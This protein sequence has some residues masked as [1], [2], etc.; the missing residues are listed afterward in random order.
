MASAD[1]DD[2]TADPFL[3]QAAY[4]SADGS[5]LLKSSLYIPPSNYSAYAPLASTLPRPPAVETARRELPVVRAEGEV[6]E[7]LASSDVV[8]LCGE[9]GSGKTTQ[10]PQMLLE[11]G[12]ATPADK[13]QRIPQAEVGKD[14]ARPNA[15]FRGFPGLIAVTQPR[16]VAATSMAH[17]VAA[18]LGATVGPTGPVGYQIRYSSGTVGPGTRLKFCTDGILLREA[19]SDLLLSK[20]SAIILDEAHERNVNTD[21]LI[22][23]L[24][25]AVTLRNMIAREQAEET[26]AAAASPSSD[27]A[28][29]SCSDAGAPLPLGPLKLIIMSATLRVGD[30]TGNPHL[31]PRPV[32]P[33]PSL[34]IGS[35]GSG[36]PPVLNVQ[37]RQ[38]PVTAHFA[39]KTELLD[40][41]GEAVAKA[42]KVHARLPEGGILI[43]LTGA[44]E[45]EDVVKRLRQRFDPKRLADTRE[46]RARK[47]AAAAASAVA[48]G[49]IDADSAAAAASAAATS[50]TAGGASPS[51]TAADTAAETPDASGDTS[52]ATPDGDQSVPAA[53]TPADGTED[54]EAAAAEK[55]AAAG[56][57]W[58]L[59]LYA[60]L[61]PAAQQKVFSPPPPGHRLI[62][63]A[64]NV[65]E[66]SLT[67]PGIR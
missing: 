32:P 37:A 26:P 9:T 47:A 18:E 58:A 53:P 56:P 3:A 23:L 27:G 39:R 36:W 43:F 40:Y 13:L 38:F 7:T 5:R 31:F 41:V 63:V 61:P 35:G 10:V 33:P 28:S 60:L 57:V 54:D 24:G 11:A 19:S 66:T 1:D 14:A 59:P 34:S 52:A 51:S 25:R 45:V 55:D 44:D 50:S 29:S 49:T 48:S 20:Y 16:R 6:L 12:Y 42:A 17:R 30:F 21:V 22:G 8:I 62:I 4:W 2:A 67:I 15:R 65:A 64:T 46:K